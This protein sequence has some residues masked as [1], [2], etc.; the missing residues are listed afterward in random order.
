MKHKRLFLRTLSVLAFFLMFGILTAHA[1]KKSWVKIDGTTM[2]FLY[3]E[4]EAL[5]ENEYLLNEG[6]QRPCME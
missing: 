6:G 1:E 4:K 3:G 2:T 5:A